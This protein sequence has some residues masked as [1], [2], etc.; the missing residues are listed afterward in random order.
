MTLLRVGSG[1]P[2]VRTLR[3]LRPDFTAN[4]V[5]VSGVK[6]HRCWSG[7]RSIHPAPAA[8]RS[9][10]RKFGTSITSRPCGFNKLAKW[11]RLCTGS[12]RCSST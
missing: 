11:R 3:T 7:L 1:S 2:N 5:S 8:R 6:C 9:Q 10:E 4:R 12:D